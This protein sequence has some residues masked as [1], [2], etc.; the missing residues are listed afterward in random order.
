[1]IDHFVRPITGGTN[2]GERPLRYHYWR[3]G[4]GQAIESHLNFW[5]AQA[6]VYHCKANYATGNFERLTFN[7]QFFYHV[8]GKATLEQNGTL[9]RL[10]EGDLL[11]VPKGTAFRYSSKRGMR[12]HWFAVNG[13][14]P[15]LFFNLERVLPLDY[16]AEIENKF[17]EIRETLILRQQGYDLQA[18]GL[19]FALVSRMRALSGQ[20]TLPESGY[21]DVV[22]NA[23]YL[24]RENYKRPFN[25]AEVAQAVGLSSAHLH[26]LF[27]KWVGESPQ[28]FHTRYR[29]EQ[30]KRLLAQQP[31]PI[32]EVAYHIGFSD[33][34]YFA[35]VFKQMTG[36]T[37]SQ[38]AKRDF[39]REISSS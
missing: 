31:L 9:C 34:R 13:C 2:Y 24:L 22:R 37:P 5:V 12:Y 11:I 26:T 38:Y 10:R 3:T 35:R 39:A 6:G 7:L 1:M 20:T 28:R 15:S 25:A 17:V 16:D 23:I 32:F 33:A 4:Y 14:W 19:A 36:V 8:E 21:P 29:I 27:H 30:A 18:I